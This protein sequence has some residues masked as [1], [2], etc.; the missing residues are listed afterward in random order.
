MNA[1]TID[2]VGGLRDS[3][4]GARKSQSSGRCSH[5]KSPHGGPP[6]VLFS[7]TPGG[8]GRRKP[9]IVV[10]IAPPQG[11]S[12]IRPAQ[13]AFRENGFR[14]MPP[15]LQAPGR[16]HLAVS[17]KT[18]DGVRVSSFFPEASRPLT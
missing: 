4:R 11:Q 14:R 10:G 16:L 7:G 3:E 2:N 17:K 13:I 1:R 9:T 8:A 6:K 18:Y 5:Q 15:K 12:E